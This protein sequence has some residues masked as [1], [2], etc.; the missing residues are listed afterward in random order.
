[1]RAEEFLKEYK[2]VDRMLVR[3]S[4]PAAVAFYNRIRGQFDNPHDAME[5]AALE[6]GV[7]PRVLQ[8][9]LMDTGLFESE[10]LDEMYIAFE[11]DE[12]S[13]RRLA[14]QFPPKY[15][16]LIG[17]HITYKRNVKR[18]STENLPETPKTVN[19][20]GYA[21]DG[22]G[23]EALVVSINGSKDRLDG[24]TY[25][26]TWSLDRDKGRKP[27]D[28]NN[29]VATQGFKNVSPIQIVVKPKL[30]G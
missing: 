16:E 20:I 27:V 21:D 14:Q 10:R 18:N 23:I 11:L 8:T 29:L 28:S 2:F 5:K 19:V 4:L 24:G 3:K 6:L 9:Y 13:R 25:H 22:E 17:H 1:M 26:I 7:R 15:P 12:T 30:L